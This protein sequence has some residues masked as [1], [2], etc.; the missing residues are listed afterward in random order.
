LLGSAATAKKTNILVV[1]S[2]GREHALAW[3]LRQSVR[4]ERLYVAP[5]NGGTKEFNVP[6]GSTELKKLRDFA[7]E[8]NCFTIVGPEAPLASGIVDEFRSAGVPIFGPTVEQA[9]LESS[10]SFAKEFMKNHAIPTADFRIFD[11]LE[12][13]LDYSARNLGNVVVKVDGLASGK[14]VF[15][16]S[17]MEEAEKAIRLI[18]EKK[19]FG[20]AGGKVVIEEKLQG[21]E[22]SFMY[23]CDGKTALDFGT[24]VDHKR[25]F[26][27]DKGPNTGGM[28]AFSPAP[29]LSPD[30]LTVMRKKIVE[31]VMTHSK[32][33]GFLYLGLMFDS[34][35]LPWVLEFNARLGDPE[36]QAI[37]P[38][39]DSDLLSVLLENENGQGFRDEGQLTWS[40]NRSCTVV[41]CSEGYPESPKTGD[42]ISGVSRAESLSN[43]IVFHS[44]TVARDG[45]LY[46][47]GGRVLS[48]TGLGL[49]L[50]EAATKA[51]EAVSLIS[52]R[53]ERHRMDISSQEII[54]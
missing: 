23:L 22:A 29:E 33:R 3:K 31:P 25:A 53:G 35:D 18:L 37:L 6:I 47:N 36:A 42:V 46:T 17:T 15:V 12:K 40:P 44:G 30:E 32:F 39:L 28:G 20:K 5:G 24:A 38:R 9:R 50:A 41:M 49:S 8:K 52:W 27:G 4:I 51:Y 1:G 34:H 48:V 26:D 2:G 45:S 43:A 10:K 54:S 14:G 7:A 16:C 19:A 11:D 21:R 13:A